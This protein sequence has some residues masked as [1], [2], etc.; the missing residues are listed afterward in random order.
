MT[1][2][3]TYSGAG[4][5]AVL[6]AVCFAAWAQVTV[7]VNPAVEY[8]TIEG[9][10]AHGS[11][12]VWWGGGPFYNATF[13][14]QV[15]D[16]LGFTMTRNN[17]YPQNYE[18]T[19]DNNDPNTFGTFSS[20]ST[21]IS[22]QCAFFIALR[23][24][25]AQSNEP[26]RFIASFW[27]PPIWMKVNNSESGGD[28]ATNILKT[29]VENELAEL[30]A[31]AVKA[32]KDQCNIDLYALSMQNEPA[33]DE[34]YESCVY[35]AERYRDVFKIFGERVKAMYPN[36]KLF[37]AE[38]MLSRWAVGGYPG[39]LMAD[40]T[41][42]RL[43]DALAVHGYSDGVHPTPVAQAVNLWRISG[44]QAASVNKPLWMTETSGYFD[45]WGDAFQVAEAIYA[46]L[47]YGKLAAWVWW[48]LSGGAENSEY[49][50]F[51]A[52]QPGKRA[53][54]HKH[55]ARYIRPDAVG[56]GDSLVGDSLVFSVA[57][58]HKAQQTLTVILLNANSASRTVTLAGPDMPSF[59]VY[60][61]TAGENCVDAGTATT[62]VTLP[63]NSVVT[64][65][66]QNY[67]PST[68]T[69]MPPPGRRQTRFR[70]D[71][72]AVVY[73]LNGV[74]TPQRGS[75]LA[76]GVRVV[77]SGSSEARLLLSRP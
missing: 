36:V 75:S 40:T 26:M 66:G 4:T 13:L 59:T 8:Q 34:P 58:R 44:N 25:A 70:A 23:D 50:M 65:Y 48:Q 24:K 3:R 42:R 35:T 9:F 10:G 64:L 5:I 67:D 37:G 57:F 11:M 43:M 27:S 51:V 18:P 63:A 53:Y 21:F 28:P 55:Y 60:R 62:S 69:R 6:S 61:S 16:D 38:D 49:A 68:G 2:A 71:R 14:N 12:N 46:A 1:R 22:K 7:T 74:R 20:S 54:V 31:A 73:S 19:N 45:D 39:R 72:D 41:S 29:G 77:S 17:F 52:S 30:G 47:K 33:F 56:V 32:Y 15:V 76:G